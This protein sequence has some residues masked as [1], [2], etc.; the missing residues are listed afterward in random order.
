MKFFRDLNRE[1]F[2]ELMAFFTISVSYVY[3]FMVTFTVIPKE[4]QRFAD[5][6]L[7]SLLTIVIGKILSEY[8]NAPKLEETTDIKNNDL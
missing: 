7:G 6:I 3:M 8:F 2:K 4:N 5:I 1:D